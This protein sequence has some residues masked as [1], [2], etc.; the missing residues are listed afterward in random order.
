MLTQ[1]YSNG[2]EICCQYGD[3]FVYLELS[4]ENGV[5]DFRQLASQF[6]ER[7]EKYDTKQRFRAFFKYKDPNSGGEEEY[8]DYQVVTL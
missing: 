2:V 4:K 3:N 8:M 5:V 6:V 1:I 7:N